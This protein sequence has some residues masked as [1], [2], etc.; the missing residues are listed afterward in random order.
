MG[1]ERGQ[2]QVK[3]LKSAESNNLLSNSRWDHVFNL[4]FYNLRA[5]CLFFWMAQ[6][7]GWGLL[8]A[9][10]GARREEGCG[11][12]PTANWEAT[13]SNCDSVSKCLAGWL[14][15]TGAVVGPGQGCLRRLWNQRNICLRPC[16]CVCTCVCAYR[17]INNLF[18]HSHAFGHVCIK[19]KSNNKTLAVANKFRK[20]KNT[21]AGMQFIK[22]HRITHVF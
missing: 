14:P 19:R 4:K 15:S 10:R 17:H 8:G 22:K 20:I 9:G 11:Q 18:W 12:L 13:D 21:R 1:R 7:A 3:G 5:Q 6:G 16:V 2:R